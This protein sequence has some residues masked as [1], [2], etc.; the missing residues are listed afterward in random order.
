MSLQEPSPNSSTPQSPKNSA[1]K[2]PVS[3]RR[4]QSNRRNALRSTGPKTARGKRTVARNAI[5][6]GLLAREVVI[7]AG[8]GEEN[9]EEFHSLLEGLWDTYEPIGVVEE[10]LVQAIAAC[11]WRKARVIRAENGEIRKRLDTI[12]VDQ[13]FRNSDKGNL[14]LLS[15]EVDLGWYNPENPA[16]GKVSTTDRWSAMQVA[17]SNLRGHHSGLA[18]LRALLQKAKSEIVSDS[19]MSEKIQKKIFFALGLCDYFFALTCFNAGPPE[20]KMEDRPSD[21]IADKPTDEERADIIA[22]I[23]NR[24]ERIS[25]FEEYASEREKLAVDA[26]ARS[27]SLPLVDAADKLLRYEAHLDRQLY[28]AMDQLERVQRQRRGDNVPP[29]LNINLGQ[30]T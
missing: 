11:W 30:R 1:R 10:S 6:H 28:R 15:S 3:E 27:F 25:T 5:R 16:D 26:E 29:P 22:F 4:I 14:A 12:A 8:D 24:L 20:T 21:K 13:A 7:T 19:Y 9:L 2:R 18:Y 17:Q 23:D